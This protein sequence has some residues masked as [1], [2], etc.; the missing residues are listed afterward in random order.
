M[1]DNR[2]L[3]EVIDDLKRIAEDKGLK[4]NRMEEFM[5]AVAI[6]DEENNLK[7][8]TLKSKEV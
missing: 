2:T 8:D 4:L 6:L 3:S 7:A 1:T 5:Q